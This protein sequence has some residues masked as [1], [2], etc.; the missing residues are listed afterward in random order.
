M[1][2][3]LSKKSTKS[4]SPKQEAKSDLT[5][6]TVVD[7]T[8]TTPVEEQKPLTEE[9]AKTILT[10]LTTNLQKAAQTLNTAKA[11]LSKQQ[12]VTL[13]AQDEC[14]NA[15]QAL[16]QSEKNWLMSITG[17]QADEIKQ[18][19]EQLQSSRSGPLEEILEVSTPGA[20]KS[21]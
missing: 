8:E 15:Y 14:F 12:E 20:S 5:E 19:K 13:A 3:K 9:E 4:T 21:Q 16:S 17:K 6:T 7:S 18:L 11:A 10:N 1:S 2:T